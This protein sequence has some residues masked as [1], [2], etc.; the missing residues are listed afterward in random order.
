MATACF[1]QRCSELIVTPSIFHPITFSFCKVRFLMSK[2]V[3]QLQIYSNEIIQFGIP[4]S[5]IRTITTPLDGNWSG[6]PPKKNC[7]A[8]LSY[9]IEFYQAQL[10]HSMTNVFEKINHFSIDCD[11]IIFRS[12]MFIQALLE[13]KYFNILSGID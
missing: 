13:K 12:I 3:D 11:A 9:D 2:A 10:S 1:R 6:T 5:N 4:G 7:Y 8:R